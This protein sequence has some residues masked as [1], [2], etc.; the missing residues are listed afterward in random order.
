MEESSWEDTMVHFLREMG[1]TD[2]I[3]RYQ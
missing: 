1:D 3:W 2:L